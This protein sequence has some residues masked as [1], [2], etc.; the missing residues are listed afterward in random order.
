MPTI[1]I[2]TRGSQLA[3]YQ[4][5]AVK[6][7]LER[8]LPEIDF[9]IKVIDTKGDKI[10][11]KPL[12]EIGDKGIFTAE[13]EKELKDGTIDFAVHSL[14]D[15][16][17][18][19]P[20]TLRVSAVLPRA[21]FRDALVAKNA[22]SLADLTAE[23]VV[24]TS[25]LRRRAQ[26]LHKYKNLNITDIRGNVNTRLQKFDNGVCSAMVMAA[27]GLQRLGFQDRIT[28]II[29]KD[30]I[31]PAACQGVIAVETCSQNSD[32]EYVARFI[33]DVETWTPVFAERLLLKMINGGC[34]T[35]FGCY[36]QA[37]KTEFFVK[38]FIS[39]P[40]GSNYVEYSDSQSLDNAHLAAFNTAKYLLKNGGEDILKEIKQ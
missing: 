23:D 25:S 19:L 18:E 26:L 39:M 29:D 36:T 8:E 14:K 16:P 21:E 38:A 2:G 7:A 37:T 34:K 22:K 28:Q 32:A 27:A 40:D 31:I 30:E 4:A 17:A 10:L 35:P 33:N 13:I 3:L 5:N 20:D 9:E 11:N 15:L 1:I 24:A 6:Q 12:A